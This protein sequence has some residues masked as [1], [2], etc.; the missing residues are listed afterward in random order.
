MTDLVTE[1]DTYAPILDDT[2][3]YIDSIPSAT[4]L[5]YGMKC[6]CIS[7]KNGKLFTK[8]CQFVTHIRTDS[9]K[10]WLIEM[11]ANKQNYFVESEE[12]REIVKQQRKQI[13][14][15]DKKTTQQSQ[16]IEYLSTKLMKVEQERDT[17]LSERHTNENKVDI[18]LLDISGLS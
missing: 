2:A 15:F 18:D 6:P 4:L 7:R 17:L 10:R 14:D 11:N 12:L 16:L 8:R 9:H 13:A 5:Q 1:P 3:Q